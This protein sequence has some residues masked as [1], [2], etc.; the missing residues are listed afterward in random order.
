MLKSN[1]A[2]NEE[3]VDIAVSNWKLAVRVWAD[4]V[5]GG[6]RPYCIKIG[7]SEHT[8]AQSGEGSST[9]AE[10]SRVFFGTVILDSDWLT[11]RVTWYSILIGW[12]GCLTRVTLDSDWLP[13][14]LRFWARAECVRQCIEI[15]NAHFRR[16][17]TI[18]GTVRFFR[19]NSK[20]FFGSPARADN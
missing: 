16:C 17:A 1:V 3:S 18:F 2:L 20:F 10:S 5:G 12:R 14:T 7:Y 19:K 15:G 9:L 13:T 4:Q 11:T 8:R 6:G